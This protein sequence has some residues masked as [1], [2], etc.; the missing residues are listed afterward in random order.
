[1][2]KSLKAKHEMFCREFL[3]DLNATQ[4]AVRVGYAVKRAHVTSAELMANPGIQ[5]RINE[6]KEQRNERT[7]INV[8][9]VL[10]RLAEIDQMD[11]ADILA[12]GGGLKPICDWP[13]VWRTSLCGLDIESATVNHDETTTEYILKKIKWPDK[14]KNLALLGKHVNV[15]A[16]KEVH[17]HNVNVTLA[18][19]MAKARRR[20]AG[21]G[22]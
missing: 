11:V 17:E 18:D 12:D 20:A 15:N 1:M 2:A 14:V 19:R 5:Q 7:D 3:V 22:D 21:G 8:D 4:A 10:R 6:L 13:K 9:Y 16:F